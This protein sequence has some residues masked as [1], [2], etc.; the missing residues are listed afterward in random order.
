[1]EE[2]VDSGVLWNVCWVGVVDDVLALGSV[3]SSAVNT[4]AVK[5]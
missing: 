5:P 4:L 3:A 2:A 1:M